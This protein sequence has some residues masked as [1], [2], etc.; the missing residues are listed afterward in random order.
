MK[1][2]AALAGVSP[3]TVSNVITGAAAVRGQTRERVESAMRELDFVPNLS[4]RGLRNG[5][6]GVI[7]V[8]LPDLAT[9]FSASLTKM[10]VELAHDRGLVVQIEETSAD[11]SREF[12]LVSRA[13]THLIDGLILNSITLED[14]VVE[15]VGH[16]PPVVLIGEVEQHRADRVYIDSRGAAARMTAHVLGQGARRVAVIGGGTHGTEGNATSKLRVQGHLD[17]LAAA[18]IDADPALQLPD[19]SWTI[20]GGAEGMRSLLERGTPFDA[21]VAFTDSM[22]LGALQALYAEGVRVPEDVLIAGFDD[23]E[24]ASFTHPP[25]STISF[26]LRAY[27]AAALDLLS[28][29][30]ADRSRA[31]QAVEVPYSL[32]PRESTA[33]RPRGTNG[34]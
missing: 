19:V 23:V 27:V 34:K 29:R 9:A 22:A 12:A 15:H 7:G 11:P 2:V 8:A 13:R 17:A 31:P 24:H 6:T 28:S 32:V 20:S 1:D 3:K 26:D 18:G 21:V 25:L 5:R 16:L 4:A 14:S 10:I 30:F 33:A